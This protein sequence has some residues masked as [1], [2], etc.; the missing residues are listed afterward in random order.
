MRWRT[1][2]SFVLMPAY[3]ADDCFSSHSV[4]EDEILDQVTALRTRLLAQLPQ[5][6]DVKSLKPSD[7]HALAEAKTAQL[8]RFSGAFGISQ[9][10]REGAAFDRDEQERLRAAKRAEYEEKDRLRLER[11]REVERE[12]ET[13]REA[14]KVARREDERRCVCSRCMRTLRPSD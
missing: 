2:T 13:R 9:G 7:T 10:Y 5:A 11:A 14:I 4:P 3:Q 12:E 6:K 1:L 8:A